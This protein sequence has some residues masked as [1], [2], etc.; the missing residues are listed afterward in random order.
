MRGQKKKIAILGSTG[1][2]GHSSLSVLEALG[3]DY[4]LISASAHRQWEILARLARA[5]H[6]QKVA[7]TDSSHLPDLHDAL[8]GT[9]IQISSGPQSLVHL[10]TDENC[11]IVIVAIVGAAGLPA[12]LAATGA[13][14]PQQAT[15]D[16]TPTGSQD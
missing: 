6:L 2:I 10:A 9:N 12:V 8:A 11:D 15:A 16:K 13:V 1:S 3:P 5:H 4:R 7:L 14:G